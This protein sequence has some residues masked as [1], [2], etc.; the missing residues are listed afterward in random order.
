MTEDRTITLF[1]SPQTRSSA[2][3]AL[4]EELGAPYELKVLNMKAGDQ[5]RPDYLAINPMGKVPAILDCGV[6]VTEQVAIVIHLADR[7]PEAGLAPALGDPRR[8]AY[9][10]WLAFYAGCFEPA[11]VDR[12]LQHTPPAGQSIYRDFDTML[13]IL[14]AQLAEGPYLLGDAF[15]AADILWGGSLRWTMMFGI[16]P[17]RPV[18]AAYA[19]R[20]GARAA[21]R[22]IDALDATLAAEHEAAV[23]PKAAAVA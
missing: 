10:R 2:T 21:V 13:D 6:L 19:D 16:V 22:K 8:G 3:L 15:T 23:A 18:F 14:E 4:L 17:P 1:H 5:R 7:F 12:F 20:I 9:L 11:V